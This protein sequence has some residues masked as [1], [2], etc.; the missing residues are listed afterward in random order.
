VSLITGGIADGAVLRL[1]FHGRAFEFVIDNAG[2]GQWS[3]H[4]LPHRM[5]ELGIVHAI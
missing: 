2:A 1:R 5:N 4:L 3:R